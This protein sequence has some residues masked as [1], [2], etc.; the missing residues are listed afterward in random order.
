MHWI[1]WYD[2]VSCAFRSF[3]EDEKESRI[4]NRRQMWRSVQSL[5]PAVRAVTRVFRAFQSGVKIEGVISLLRS[6][7]LKAYSHKKIMGGHARYRLEFRGER[8]ICQ[9][10]ATESSFWTIQPLSAVRSEFIPDEGIQKLRRNR[11]RTGTFLPPAFAPPSL[12]RMERK[13]MNKTKTTK[14]RLSR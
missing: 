11:Q 14:N 2:C 7:S 12:H 13:Y 10:P 6:S 1:C 8:E 4:K 3:S 5:L 9:L